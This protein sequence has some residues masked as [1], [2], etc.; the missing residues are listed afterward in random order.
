MSCKPLGDIL[1]IKKEKVKITWVKYGRVPIKIM[2]WD[3]DRKREELARSVVAEKWLG[4][5]G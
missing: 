3:W 1:Q 4:K 5:K 2:C